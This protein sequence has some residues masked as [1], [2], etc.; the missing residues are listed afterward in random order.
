MDMVRYCLET[1]TAEPILGWEIRGRLS[2]GVTL[3]L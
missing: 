1:L 3:T 2:K